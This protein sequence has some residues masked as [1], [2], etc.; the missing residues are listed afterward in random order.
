MTL[1]INQF[2]HFMLV[3]F[4]L[5]MFTLIGKSKRTRPK[6]HN[7][8]FQNNALVNYVPM[9]IGLFMIKI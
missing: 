3:L 8:S 6:D 1:R 7:F 4:W 2:S 5:A 9:F